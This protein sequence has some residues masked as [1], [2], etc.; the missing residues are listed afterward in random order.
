MT[1]GR[2]A[3]VLLIA[4]FSSIFVQSVSAFDFQVFTWERGKIQ[5][6]IIGEAKR[7]TTWK[8]EMVGQGIEP[9][10]FISSSQNDAG[11]YVFTAEIPD[12]TPLGAYSIEAT[13]DGG[14]KR[15]IAGISLIEKTTY[16]ITKTTDLTSVIALLT[17]ITASFSTLRALKYSRFRISTLDNLDIAEVEEKNILKRIFAY[18]LNLRSKLTNGVNPS[19][20]RHLLVQE[21]ATL[22]KLSKPAYHLFP[23]AGIVLGIVAGF[24]A[25]TNAGF[26]NTSLTFFFLMS[27]IGLIDAFSGISALL[28]FWL[29]QFYFG[30]IS[31]L[32]DLL[33]VS[34]AAIAWIGPALLSR[35]FLDSI[36]I[37]LTNA[38][39]KAG[40]LWAKIISIAFSAITAISI[41]FGGHL[42]LLSL[43][44][45]VSDDFAMKTH[46]ILVIGV[47]ALIK[48]A[49]LSFIPEKSG[50]DN[51][52]EFEV[53]RIVSPQIAF[54][55]F[56][57]ILGYAY[58]WTG[59]FGRA[60]IAAALFATPYLLLL[61]RFESL[62]IH[63]FAKVRRNLVLEA[64]ITTALSFVIYS[65][66]Q[67]LPE[68]TQDRTELFLILAGFPVLI[69][70]LYSSICDSA[71][72]KERIVP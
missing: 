11:Y 33:I 43:I 66:M 65:Q 58:I 69:H 61:V 28:S 55:A 16:D 54:V 50:Q 21:G 26:E 27:I 30:E 10:P 13:G 25:Q 36:L 47:V 38:K 23:L 19:L 29:V 45:D 72:R 70:G 49:S 5:Q 57:A 52:E 39:F 17:F 60:I 40:E 32:R 64:S 8:V 24:D 18:L 4:I 67:R 46:Y 44:L 71:Q 53:V 68:L 34:A 56:G 20:L 22:K 9:I 48:A 35:L 63:Q 6:V 31:S 37:D 2:A 12:E 7:G 51:S 41:F 3:L 15:I 1:K 14:T 62:A 59:N 42:L